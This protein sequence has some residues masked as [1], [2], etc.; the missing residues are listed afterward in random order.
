MEARKRILVV[1]DSEDL[2]DFYKFVLEDAGYEVSVAPSGQE[3]LDQAH[4][5]RPDLIILDVVMPGMGG[6]EALARIRSDLAPPVPPVILCSGFDMA[7]GE[8]LR[9]GA[10][11]FVRKPFTV[12]G[13]LAYVKHGVLGRPVSAEVDERERARTTAARRRAREAAA[14]LAGEFMKVFDERKGASQHALADYFGVGTALFALLD[15]DR[16]TVLGLIGDPSF[17]RGTDLGEKLPESYEILETGTSLVIPDA[18]INPCF[19]AKLRQVAGVRFFAGV[20][21]LAPDKTPIGVLCVLDARPRA[22]AAEDLLI[23]EHFGC[24][25]SQRLA[26]VRPES[27]PYPGPGVFDRETFS[28]L[29]DAEA[30]L[31]HRDG[32]SMELGVV[33]VDDVRTVGEAV[34][35]A[36]VRE[37]LA[38]SVVGATR[39]AICKRDRNDG[40]ARQVEAVLGEVRA[41][42]SLRAAGGASIAGSGPPAVGGQDLLHLAEVALDNALQVGGGTQ[43]LVLQHEVSAP[44]H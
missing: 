8:A 16:L 12:D 28:L 32:G 41:A 37:R 34:A 23:L 31:L 4:A 19:G 26:L 22:I 36:T 30:R 40:A 9:R 17:S 21:V 10:L 44:M 13:L 7:E 18:S 2:R 29:I 11:M 39:V 25:V 14:G 27:G 35:H 5:R 1:D 3:G 20:P 15:D 43:R 33:E 24:V 38:A 6:L 42:G